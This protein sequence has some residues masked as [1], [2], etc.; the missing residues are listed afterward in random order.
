MVRD[1]PFWG[2][3]K[4]MGCDLRRCNSFTLFNLFD[5]HCSRSFSH[6]DKIST[7]VVCVNS[8]H[9]RSLFLNRVAKLSFI[10]SLK[11]DP[12][13]KASGGRPLPKLRGRCLLLGH[14]DHFFTGAFFHQ[15]LSHELKAIREACIKLEVGY[16]PGITFIVVQKRHHTRLFCQDG[17]DKVGGCQT[18]ELRSEKKDKRKTEA[19]IVHVS[20]TIFQSCLNTGLN[21]TIILHMRC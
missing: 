13:L 6:H 3:S 8:K 15:V 10:V 16:Q 9:P 17:Q 21:N 11:Q 20:F 14:N 18:N 5:I 1:I 19:S 12:E 7:R 4:N 2:A